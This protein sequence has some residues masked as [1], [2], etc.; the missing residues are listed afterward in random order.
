MNAKKVVSIIFLCGINN[1][2]NV[3]VCVFFPAMYASIVT[4]TYALGIGISLVTLY[5][6]I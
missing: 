1:N 3:C 4:H 6:K 5:N 2:A